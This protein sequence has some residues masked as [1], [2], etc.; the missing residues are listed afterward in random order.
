[1]QKIIKNHAMSSAKCRKLKW[2]LLFQKSEFFC[3][4]LQLWIASSTD[5]IAQ[6]CLSLMSS[7]ILFRLGVLLII[8]G[9]TKN[10]PLFLALG[11]ILL[12]VF[13]CGIPGV[14]V[15]MHYRRVKRKLNLDLLRSRAASVKRNSEQNASLT[16][17]I[18]GADDCVL[19]MPLDRSSTEDLSEVWNWARCGLLM[20]P[21]NRLF[22][23]EWIIYRPICGLFVN[24]Y[25]GSFF[26]V[27]Y[28]IHLG[29]L[30]M[31]ITCP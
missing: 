23:L 24:Y 29:H 22:T 11:L 13:T 28:L 25:D 17:N 18:V 5:I 30:S 14:Y 20:C 31:W 16:R 21:V 3:W 1:M 8:Y 4:F 19:P 27:D 15:G 9:H 2:F 6:W 26:C 12:F 7:H 10:V